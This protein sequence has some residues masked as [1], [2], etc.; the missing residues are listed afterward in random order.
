MKALT[1]NR[2][3]PPE[4]LE[5]TEVPDPIAGPGEVRV[6]LKAVGLN[7][8]DV[9]RRR[10][11]YHLAGDPPWIAGYEGAGVV[12][13]VGQGVT[14]VSVG[15]RVGFADSPFAN[16]ELAVVEAGK[17]LPLT[18]ALSFQQAASVMLQGLTAQYLVED[19]HRLK[20]D[21]TVLVHAAA[22]G[23]GLLLCQM[24]ANLGAKVFAVASTEAKRDAAVA[25]GAQVAAGSDWVAAARAFAPDGFDVVYDSVG[26]TLTDSLALARVGGTV[27]FYGFAGGSP[28]P[29]DPRV[30]MDRSLTLTGGDLWNVLT[31]AEARRERAAR[32]FSQVVSGALR[33]TVAATFPL[34]DG[35]A[36]HR[37]LESRGV[38]GKILLIP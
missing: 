29:V 21:Q 30:L 7:Y 35:A 13:A 9:Y 16:A 10:G 8:A 37:L 38:I 36:A 4:V 5:L 26:T 2:F 15:D 18:Y 14:G 24:A 34:A 32:L 31:T 25:A 28:Q 20:P 22:G 23:V 19:S 1:F 17:V 6:R 11:D 27:V 12:E 3:G 33:P